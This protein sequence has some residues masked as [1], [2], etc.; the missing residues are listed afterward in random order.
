MFTGINISGFCVGVSS[1][2]WFVYKNR[3]GA[4]W[5]SLKEELLCENFAK[6]LLD[7]DGGYV[8]PER[9][10]RPLR[11]GREGCWG[12]WRHI[13]GEALQ[14]LWKYWPAV[15]PRA[16]PEHLPGSTLSQRVSSAAGELCCVPVLS[17]DYYTW[18]KQGQ[19]LMD[20]SVNTGQECTICFSSMQRQ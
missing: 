9:S 1:R 7:T 13:S 11:S 18:Q 19:T 16:R 15:G 5:V 2:L 8:I 6:C 20:T 12:K 4:L 3:N 17:W 10:G 14:R